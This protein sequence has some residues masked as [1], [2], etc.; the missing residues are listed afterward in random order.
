MLCVT[1]VEFMRLLIK[2]T[3]NCEQGTKF[4]FKDW[5]LATHPYPYNIL[6]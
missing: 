6:V 5:D 4:D 1:Y 2:L 3:Q